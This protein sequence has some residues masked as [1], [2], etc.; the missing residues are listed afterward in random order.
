MAF[1]SG[2]WQ[3]TPLIGRLLLTTAIAL[4][5]AGSA[6]VLVSARQD[7]ADIRANLRRA[8]E[9]ELE[10]LPVLLAEMIVIGDFTALQQMLDQHALRPVVHTVRFRDNS[11]TLLEGE[12]TRLRREPPNWFAAAFDYVPLSGTAPINIGGRDYGEL[13]LDLSPAEPALRAWQRL[14]NHLLILSL[15]VFI[16]FIG[17][18]LVL[19]YS[20]RPIKKLAAGVDAIAAGQVETRLADT[21]GSP[22]VRGLLARF[23]E[24]AATIESTQATLMNARRSAETANLAKSQFLATMS[25]EI[26]TPMNGILGMAQLLMLPNVSEEERLEYARTLHTAGKNLM[27]LLNDILDLSKVEAGRLELRPDDF[28]PAAM[29]DEI[30]A[31]FGAPAAA[32]DLSLTARWEG[33]PQATYHADPIRLRQMLTNLVSNAIKFTEQGRVE[34]VAREVV[35]QHGRA[36]LAFSVTDTGVG[37]SAAHQELLFKPFSQVDGSTT[38]QHGGTGLGLSIVRHLAQLMGGDVGV[39]SDPGDGAT[40]WFRIWL[41]T[42]DS[43]GS[44]EKS[45]PAIRGHAP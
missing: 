25:H 45:T 14:L 16:D 31:L 12:N 7:A 21:A 44:P 23:N 9:L 34:I 4:L 20:L 1:I 37:I 2:Y 32:K 15:A 19:Y 13:Q 6:M 18:W 42:L 8:L 30:A 36:L 41:D 39:D 28:T 17:F 33:P 38:R 11:G 35:R 5:M 43:P 29:L 10:T 27:V 22:E 3:R 40:F 26:R 24:M